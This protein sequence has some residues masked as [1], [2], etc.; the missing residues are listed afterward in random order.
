MRRLA[1]LCAVSLAACQNY[2]FKDVVPA[3]T[4]LETLTP[5]AASAV[6]PAVLIVQDTSG[7]MCE[8]I[9][10]DAGADSCIATGGGTE[11]ADYCSVCLP[12]AG[13][14]GNP[15]ECT[16]TGACASKMSLVAST[17]TTALD[18]LGVDAGQL[19][20][21][22]ASF[23][24]NATC[25]TG[26]VQVPI[27]DAVATI[28]PIEQ[29]YAK[30]VPSGGTPTA[31]TL[32]AA[33]AS[34]PS[35]MSGPRYVLLITD[36]LPNCDAQNPCGTEPWAGAGGAS[37]ACASPGYLATQGIT[38]VTAPAAC[39]CSNG[40]CGTLSTTQADCC[41]FLPSQNQAVASEECLDGPASVAAVASL[42][43]AGITTYVA[44]LGYD[45]DSSSGATVLSEMA[46]AGQGGNPD[47]GVIQASSSAEL[48]QAIAGLLRKF[49]SCSIALQTTCAPA[50]I[51]VSECGRQ[52]TAGVDYTYD[53]A[54]G[55]SG[56]VTLQDAACRTYQTGSPCDGGVVI[57][58]LAPC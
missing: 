5:V 21:G 38:G 19:L 54:E 57:T 26:A 28:P 56:T 14:P 6:P 41:T 8:P 36:G 3:T 45:Y 48:Q 58:T 39:Q 30:A 4:D 22:L 16:P 33:V 52:L 46:Q 34:Q 9:Q 53:P 40:Q 17:L 37:Y 32:A 35:M 47:A 43:A 49:T 24:S 7:S 12:G 27:G 50:A 18:G 44:G 42:K 51:E 55:R 25:G 29:F 20:L 23:P 11:V 15:A 2:R 13:T 31:A 1:L 10:R